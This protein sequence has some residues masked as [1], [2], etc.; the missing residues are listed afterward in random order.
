MNILNSQILDDMVL[1]KTKKQNTYVLSDRNAFVYGCQM[2]RYIGTV[3]L[4]RNVIH[5]PDL[6]DMGTGDPRRD[7]T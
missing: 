3:G 2:C 4:T 7:P 6:S 5:G 1:L